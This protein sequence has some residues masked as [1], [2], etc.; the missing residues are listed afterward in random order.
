ML[1]VPKTPARFCFGAKQ[2]LPQLVLLP[3]VIWCMHHLHIQ[4]RRTCSMLMGSMYG[5]RISI[6]RRN[7]GFVSSSLW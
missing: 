4:H 3:T 6:S 2:K 7:A 5:L 1:Q